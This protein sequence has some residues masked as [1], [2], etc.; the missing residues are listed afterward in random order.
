MDKLVLIRAYEQTLRN[1][2]L[3]P[4]EDSR[5]YKLLFRVVH[6]GEQFL[7]KHLSSGKRREMAMMERLSILQNQLHQLRRTSLTNNTSYEATQ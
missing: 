1:Q 4:G 6:E 7:T 5:I 2:G 3:T